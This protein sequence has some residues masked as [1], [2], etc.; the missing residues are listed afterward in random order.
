MV[1]FRAKL[2]LTMKK[3]TLITTAIAL[4]GVL[5]TS[6]SKKEGCTDPAATNF[7]SE[8]EKDDGSC[9]YETTEEQP[10]VDNESQI[11]VAFNHNF[12]GLP[13]S[14]Q[15]F[16]QFNYVNANNDTLS[17]TKLRYLISDLK[18]YTLSGDSIELGNYKL[19]DLDDPTTLTWQVNTDRG[20]YAAIGFNFGFDTTDNMG[21]YTDLNSVNWNWPAGIG[22]GYHNMQFEGKYKYN[23]ADSSY[24][25]H[26]GTASNGGNHHQNHI[27]VMLGGIS[28]NQENV[29]LN[30]NMDLSQW[31]ENPILW[32]LN[33]L[34]SMLMPNY[35]AQLMMRANGYNV[36]SLGT[37]VQRIQ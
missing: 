30:I 29:T 14:K 33:A 16:N 2:N 13:V 22:G 26:Y 10:V 5:F 34:H 24:A 37:V 20:N 31:F 18:L 11:T 3:I 36:F 15:I 6:C 21:N 35:N 4:T 28:L 7:D 19:I 8:A 25:Y 23:G 9:I 27:R 17:I 12:G 32:D 1:K